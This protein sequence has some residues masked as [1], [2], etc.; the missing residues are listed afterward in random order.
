VQ[1]IEE[2]TGVRLDHVV[3]ID[4]GGF[5]K[6]T[7]ALG[8]VDM[9]VDK[10]ITSIFKPYR[11]FEKSPSRHFDGTEA[12]D[13]VR[14]RYQFAD[15]DFSRQRHQQQF[16]KALL[17]K[18]VSVGTVTNLSNFKEFVSSTASA[19]TVD[20]DFSLI[21]LGWQFRGLRSE[22]LSFLVSPN[23]GSGTIDGES[24]VLSDKTKALA[25]Y[26]AIS[27]DTLAAYLGQAS[28]AAATPGQ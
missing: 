1:T 8:G 27:K 20:K 13:Y 4:F 3:L 26:D 15:G 14:Q 22:S 6:V 7:D 18:A 10:T 9:P 2:Y 12:L 24:V 21:D 25:F 17:D 16:L 28:G 11:V 23:K 19:L 5:V